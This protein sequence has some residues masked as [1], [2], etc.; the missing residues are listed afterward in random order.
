MRNTLVLLGTVL[1]SLGIAKVCDQSYHLQEAYE[2]ILTGTSKT[3]MTVKSSKL[4]DKA[5]SKASLLNDS[6]AYRILTDWDANGSCDGWVKREIT[7]AE[8]PVAKPFGMRTVTGNSV[9]FFDGTFTYKTPGWDAYWF[10]FSD[11]T[12]GG[13]PV[14]G[15][16]VGKFKT[17]D[18]LNLWYGTVAIKITRRTKNGA[19]VDTQ[20]GFLREA[21]SHPDS[22]ALS[23]D[24]LN[25]WDNIKL[26][27]TQTVD[28]T[29]QLIRIRYD[30][31][32][33]PASGVSPRKAQASGFLAR[34]TGD[35]VLIQTG[36]MAGGSEPLAL[37]NMLGNKVATLHPTGYLYQWNG[38]TASGSDAPPGVY[39]VQSGNR[40]LGKFF[41]SR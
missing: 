18:Q 3:A 14:V 17:Q 7:Y 27:D 34:Q 28:Y 20:T 36:G 8:R 9:R 33:S 13:T 35:L 31:V 5:M 1:T 22:A 40:V 26:A 19:L 16:E 12:S 23:T 4:L 6:T 24:L 2:Y 11:T 41:L 37:Y 38:K 25:S 29:L 10:G 30:S 39:F 21:A 15:E 32:P